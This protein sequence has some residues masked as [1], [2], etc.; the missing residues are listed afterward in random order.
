MAVALGVEERRA[1]GV[2]DDGV[3]GPQG[4]PLVLLLA[5]DQVVGALGE[6]AD[7]MVAVRRLPGDELGLD[8]RRTVTCFSFRR[9]P[10]PAAWRPP[11]VLGVRFRSQPAAFVAL[12]SGPVDLGVRSRAFSASASARASTATPSWSSRPGQRGR[13]GRRRRGPRGRRARRSPARRVA[14]SARAAGRSGAGVGP[15]ASRARSSS[16]P[17]SAGRSSPRRQGASS[18]RFTLRSTATPAGS[19]YGGT[20]GGQLVGADPGDLEE[21]RS[22]AA[23]ASG[24][25]TTCSRSAWKVQPQRARIEASSWPAQNCSACRCAAGARW[26]AEHPADVLVPAGRPPGAQLGQP[27]AVQLLGAGARR[28][29]T[30]CTSTPISGSRASRSWSLSA[31]QRSGVDS[32]ETPLCSQ[33]RSQMRAHWPSTSARESAGRR[34]GC[35]AARGWPAAASSVVA[36]TRAPARLERLAREP[37]GWPRRRGAARGR[38]RCARSAFVVPCHPSANRH[39]PPAGSRGER[40]ADASR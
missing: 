6:T 7:G 28:V 24:A 5:R 31:A 37:P 29:T 8:H 32:S 15:R 19:A 9:Q 39:D 16:A 3:L 18:W 10:L 12:S 23:P 38:A 1:D 21:L 35:G 17:R 33:T 22:T 4:E 40:G 36:T 25:A 30:R 27:A 20:T 26:R 14:P 2:L 13:L 34:G 11:L